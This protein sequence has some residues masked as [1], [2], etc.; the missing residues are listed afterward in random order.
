MGIIEII[1]GIVLLIA[2]VLMIVLGLMQDQ[3]TDQNM[4]SAITGAAY[5]SQFNKNQGRT[6]EAILKKWTL[7]LAILFFVA[8]LVVTIVPVYL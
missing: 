6:K 3:K 5:D 2:C 4:A 8:T 1:G 7:W